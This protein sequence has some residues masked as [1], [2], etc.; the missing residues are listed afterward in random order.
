MGS[1][2]VTAPPHLHILLVDDHPAVRQGLALF[3]AR[4]NIV[5]IEAGG[6]AGAL[7]QIE[8]RLPDLAIVDLSLDG[9]EGL[10]LIADLHARGVPVL[11]YSMHND[12]RRVRGAIAAGALGYATK[13]ELDSALVQGIREVASGRRFVSPHAA[14]ALADDVLE[15]A[16]GDAVRKL[17]ANERKIY[18]LLGKGADTF[19]IAAALHVSNRT[20]DS[21]YTRMLVKLNVNGM[22]DLRRHAIEYFQRYAR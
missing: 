22:H 6:R 13:R 10:V 9:E 12:A 19:D 15:P 1:E 17:S 4:E 11:V 14:L 2:P 16:A 18:E 20:V 3:L 7:A 5:C 8:E 21:Y